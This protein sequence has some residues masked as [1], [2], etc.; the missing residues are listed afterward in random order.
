MLIF[1]FVVLF[2]FGAAIGSFLNVCVYRLPYEKS[3]LWPGSHCGNCFQPVRWYDDN[4]PLLSYWLLRGRCRACGVKFSIRYFCV[5]LGTALVFMSLFYLEIV[6]NY[7]QIPFLQQNHDAILDGRV[8]WRAWPLFVYHLL[9]ICFLIVTSLCDLDH[10]EIPPQR[11]AVTGT[12][13]GL[14]GGTLL[15][16]PFP[17]DATFAANKA[18]A[19]GVF[20]WPVWD[21]RQLPSWMSE[22]TFPLGFA[23]SFA[24]EAAAGMLLLRAVRFLLRLGPRDRRHGVWVTQDLMMMAYGSSSSG[25]SRSFLPSSPACFPG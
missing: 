10:M 24:G 16:W 25:G 7:L 1:W 13:V 4:V 6:E 8:P 14:I 11:D 22:G 17:N 20:H 3:I 9:L 12:I 18:I 5:E 15:A 23:T 19:S 21:P 2:A